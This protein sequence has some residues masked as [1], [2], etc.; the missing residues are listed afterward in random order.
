M[1]SQCPDIA[2][3]TTDQAQL[4]QSEAERGDREILSE[5]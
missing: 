5:K 4:A 1:G 3:D 2:T